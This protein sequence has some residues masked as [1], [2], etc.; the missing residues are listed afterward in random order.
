MTLN[1]DEILEILNKNFVYYNE[2]QIND[3][4]IVTIDSC[5]VMKSDSELTNFPFE[6]QKINGYFECNNTK[7]NTLK[8]SPKIIYGGCY[9]SKCN[10]RSLRYSPQIIAGS[11]YVDDNPLISLDGIPKFIYGSFSITVHSYTPLLKILSVVGIDT[12]YFYDVNGRLMVNI[13]QLFSKYY[14]TKNAIMKVGLE[15]I[16]LGYGNNA[17]L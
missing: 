2:A 1:K 6:F 11:F 15:L 14:E 7:L 9:L 5:C 10:L 12:F 4:G 8:G 16:R 3:S 17:R 13:S